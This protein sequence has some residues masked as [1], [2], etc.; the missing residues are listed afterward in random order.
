MHINVSSNI[1]LTD[2]IN[3]DMML[4]ND[5]MGGL[6]IAGGND[7]TNIIIPGDARSA[8]FHHEKTFLLADLAHDA[9]YECLVQAKNQYGW[10]EA[11]RIHR[12]LT[13]SNAFGTLRCLAL[14]SW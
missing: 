6:N 7:W 13:H 5:G 12:F 2:V 9:Q 11:S 14:P 3:I 4:Q 8:E 1:S 10:S